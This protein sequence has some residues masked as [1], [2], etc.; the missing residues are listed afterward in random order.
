[1]PVQDI[2]VLPWLLYLAQYRIFF[3]HRTL[4]CISLHLSPSPSK[5]D[6]QSCRDAFLL[7][8]VSVYQC[9]GAGAGAKIT[10]CGSSSGF[11]SASFLFSTDLKKF[12]IKKLWLL[13]KFLYVVTVLILL[14]QSKKVIFKVSYNNYPEPGPEPEPELEPECLKEIFSSSTT[15]HLRFS[16]YPNPTE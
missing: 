14:L 1:V 7:I 10:N 11:G 13:N 4:Y 6:R 5:L 15:L 2:F 12:Y 9:C 8:C 3:P 16:L